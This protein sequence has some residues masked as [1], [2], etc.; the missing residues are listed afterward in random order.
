MLVFDA[1]I[2]TPSNSTTTGST[3]EFH[4]YTWLQFINLSLALFD[5]I[6]QSSTPTT[7]S[8]ANTSPTKSFFSGYWTD[9]SLFF[10]DYFGVDQPFHQTTTTS[11][12]NDANWGAFVETTKHPTPVLTTMPATSTMAM[13]TNA[14]AHPPPEPVRCL[15]ISSIHYSKPSLGR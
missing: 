9:C 5:D 7:Q 1:P 15:P 3:C 8:T 4:E 12:S 6:L 11:S 10:I 13:P 14:F 2:S